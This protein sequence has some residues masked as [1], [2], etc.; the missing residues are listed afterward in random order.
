MSVVF[1]NMP[2][3]AVERPSIALGILKAILAQADLSSQVVYANIWFAEHIGLEAQQLIEST[4]PQDILGEWLFGGAAFPDFAVDDVGYLRRLIQHN[5]K[6][7][8]CGPDLVE[9]LMALKRQAGAFIEEATDRILAL[10]PD[11]VGCTSMF[12]Q[13]VASLALLRRVRARA[14]HVITMLGGANCESVMGR[15]AHQHFDWVDYVVSGEADD[16]VSDLFRKVADHGRDIPVAEV[17]EGVFAPCHRGAGYPVSKGGDGAPRAIVE[18][19]RTVPPPDYA[20]YFAELRDFLYAPDVFPGI[21]IETSRGCWWGA[22][23][24]CTFCGLNG[25]NM[26]FRAKPA[27]QAREDIETLVARHGIT[28]IQAVDNIMDTGY[29]DSLVP[30]LAERAEP[31]SVFFEVKANLKRRQLELFAKAGIKALQPGIESLDTRVLKLMRKGCAAW[32]NIQLLKWSRQYGLTLA[33]TIIFGFPDEEDAWHGE[34]AR[35]LPLMH[36]LQPGGLSRLRYDRYS[37]YFSRQGDWGLELRAGHPYREVYPLPDAALNDIAYFMEDHG[38]RSASSRSGPGFA[39]LSRAHADWQDA[40]REAGPPFWRI[41]V[42]SIR[43]DP[44]G[45]AT[46]TDTRACAVAHD[47]TL[48]AFEVAIIDAADAAPTMAQLGERLAPHAEIGTS[49]ERLDDQ[50]ARLERAGLLLTIDGRVVSLVLDEPVAYRPRLRDYPAGYVRP[51]RAR[52]RLE[53]MLS[54]DAV[55]I[56]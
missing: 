3:A 40:H 50:V 16:L 11:V 19:L 15:T 20:D 32:Q 22:K 41:P 55:G 7:A 21:P 37:P 56:G 17:P 2:V 48:S 35:L 43:R 45:G 51:V 26:S 25:G 4:R 34:T 44:C 18:D 52:R 39:A 53:R 10:K 27:D 23:S 33:W 29:I 47:T 1:V 31:L 49:A 13:H 28:R 46:L 30:G 36:H 6:L 14:P 5:S 12:Q 54:L 38:P 8:A 24:H 42:L 9:R